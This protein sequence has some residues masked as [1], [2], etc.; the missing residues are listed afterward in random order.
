M[1]H[2]SSLTRQ[3]TDDARQI[4]E[5]LDEFQQ[6]QEA[7]KLVM[8]PEELDAWERQ[9]G[10]RTDQLSSLLLGFHLQ[11]T[12]DSDALQAEQVLLVSHSVV[13]RLRVGFDGSSICV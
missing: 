12:L 6:M 13:E 2:D 3:D 11:Q 10:Q 9:M 5:L 8:S 1:A 7:P 4:Q